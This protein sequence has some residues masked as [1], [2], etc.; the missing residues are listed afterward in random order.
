MANAQIPEIAEIDDYDN[1]VTTLKF[2]SGGLPNFLFEARN[3]SCVFSRV[4]ATG[5]TNF[6]NCKRHCF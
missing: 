3:S 6:F 5:F 1:V 2:P 4:D